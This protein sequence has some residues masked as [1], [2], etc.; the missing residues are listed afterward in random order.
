MVN[1]EGEYSTFARI[2]HRELDY[3]YGVISMFKIKY[4]MA[5]HYA[6]ISINDI[7]FITVV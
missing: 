7:K 1:L 4:T 2:F 5:F 6:E 3:V